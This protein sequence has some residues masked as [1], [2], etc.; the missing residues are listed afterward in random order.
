MRCLGVM[1]F[2]FACAF[3]M[4]QDV[5]PTYVSDWRAFAQTIDD[6]YPFF[7]LKNVRGDW[8]AAK[9]K[10]EERV[11]A[12]ASDEEFLG[13][14]TDAFRVLRD[15]HMQLADTRVLPPR[16]EPEYCPSIGFMP[17]ADKKVIVMAGLPSLGEIAKTGTEITHI[18]GV[19]AYEYLEKRAEEDWKNAF[20]S[21][22]QRARLYTYRIPLRGKQ[23]D[24]H[25]VRYVAGGEEKET[26]LTCDTEARG[27]PHTYNF[28]EN[29]TV[30]G[31]S[32]FFKKLES[33]VGYMH[34]RRVDQGI[35]EGMKQAFERVTDTKGWIVDLRGNGGG[36]Y[37]SALVDQVK[38]MPK[39]VAVI[40]DA[41][42]ISAGETLAR[43]F[44]QYA[45]ARLFGTRTAGASSS[46]RK[47]QFP[48]GIGSVS[49]ATRSRY[50]ADGK[51]IEFN[52]IDPDVVVEPVAEEVQ[53]GKNTEILRA[54]EYLLSVSG[55]QSAPPKTAPES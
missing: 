23:G 8:D 1:S 35:V 17:A 14:V 11:A 50:R 27:W 15:S 30:F 6:T 44:A 37:D 41:G 16:P 4:A 9:P 38:S 36:G 42:C 3:V 18:D 25:T 21:S 5:R 31:R 28:P 32:C 47:W 26:T 7:D 40:V 52:G 33:G 22:P 10:L 46:K 20:S 49:M 53:Q 54:E 51:P 29:M 39:P 13:I 45:D 12:C 19:N 24:T 2:V 43:D 34:L 48:S 55:T